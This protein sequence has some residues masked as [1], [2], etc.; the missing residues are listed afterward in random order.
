LDE[1]SLEGIGFFLHPHPFLQ[2]RKGVLYSSPSPVERGLGG[3]EE[4]TTHTKKRPSTL[5]P[6]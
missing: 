2:R 5:G 6:F 1:K 3:E 4:K